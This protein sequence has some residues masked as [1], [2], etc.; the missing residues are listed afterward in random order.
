VIA[1]QQSEKY[2]RN[3]FLAPAETLVGV[4]GVAAVTLAYSVL[5][6]AAAAE[7]WV[8]VI[9]ATKPIVDLTWRIEFM[10]VLGQRVN[11]QSLVAIGAILLTLVAS[12]VRRENLLVDRYIV[13]LLG[14]AILSTVISLTSAG[15]DELIRFSC[16]LCFFFIAGKAIQDQTGFDRFVRAFLVCVLVPVVLGLL[17]V[18]GLLPYEYWDWIDGQTV[19]RLSGTY[20]H[21]LGL[22]YFLLFAF[23]LSLYLLHNPSTS[24]KNKILIVVGFPIAT[25]ALVLTYHRTGLI[26]VALEIVMWYWLT[27]R[28]RLKYILYLIP[29]L[30]LAAPTYFRWVSVLYDP[31][32]LIGPGT[33]DLFRG[34]GLNWILF[35]M[36]LFASHPFYWFIGKG[37]SLAQGFVPG[38]GMYYSDEAHNDFVRILYVYGIIGIC[39][40]LAVLYRLFKQAR[41]IRSRSDPFSRN[42]GNITLAILPAF[43]LMS[44]TGEPLRYPTGAWYLF[45]LASIVQA[46][47]GALIR[48]D[49]H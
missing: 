49:R 11:S 46:R 30:L 43:L 39:L 36:S 38:F 41:V 1:I 22:V 9:L 21:P 25:A 48:C 35:L 19:G 27:R 23:P 5:K 18:A 3:S 14:C 6:V 28:L 2:T 29:V 10:N 47:C 7:I 45:A 44:M 8:P 24:R 20:Q 15:L 40:Y 42:L 33:G 16:G 34:R 13:A 12:V 37:V 32:N 26:A 17:Q 31:S 4:A